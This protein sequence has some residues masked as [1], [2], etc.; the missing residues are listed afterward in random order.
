LSSFIGF[1]TDLL[2]GE[3]PAGSGWRNKLV[4]SAIEP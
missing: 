3:V 1:V 2:R 4:V